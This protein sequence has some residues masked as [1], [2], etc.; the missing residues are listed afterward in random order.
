M[1]IFF[2]LNILFKNINNLKLS[3]DKYY[4]YKHK[5]DFQFDFH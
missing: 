5:D 2:I 1:L 4:T 3:K